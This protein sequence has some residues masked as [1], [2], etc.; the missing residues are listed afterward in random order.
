MSKLRMNVK[1]LAA[2]ALGIAA[3][4]TASAA[5]GLAFDVAKAEAYTTYRSI[6]TYEKT[7]GAE[8]GGPGAGGEYRVQ[9]A[10][11]G[12]NVMLN[13][14]TEGSASLVVDGLNVSVSGANAIAFEYQNV[15]AGSTVALTVKVNGTEAAAPFTYW[16]EGYD[17]A[18]TKYTDAESLTIVSVSETAGFTGRIILPLASFGSVSSIRSLEFDNE[19]GNTVVKNNF[20]KATLVNVSEENVPTELGEVWV[21]AQNNY[22]VTGTAF[23]RLMKKGELY[24]YAG[25][26]AYN[27]LGY[28]VSFAETVPLAEVKGL[29]FFV[30][31]TNVSSSYMYF[32]FTFR[33]G[34]KSVSVTANSYSA[35]YM[36]IKENGIAGRTAVN[37][38]ADKNY[39]GYMYFDMSSLELGALEGGLTSITVNSPHKSLIN[40]SYYMSDFALVTQT[41]GQLFGI[42]TSAPEGGSVSADKFYVAYGDEVTFTIAADIP[43]GYEKTVKV[44]G[45]N[46]SAELKDGLLTVIATGDLETALSYTPIDYTISYYDENGG[47]LDAGENPVSYNIES[48]TITLVGGA[49]RDGFEFTGWYDAAEGGSLVT[50]IATGSTGDKKLYARY[51]E[52]KETDY[53][54]SYY[55]GD[56]KLAAGEN[57]LFYNA[58]SGEILL[59]DAP[60]KTGYVFAGWCDE[61]GNKAAGI[62]AGSE[63]N[64]IF[65]AKYLLLYTISYYDEDG[66]ALYAG[67][68]PDSYTVES[69]RITLKEAAAKEGKIF[70]GWYD[71]REGGNAVVE[72]E[73]GSTGNKVLYARYE[74]IVYVVTYYDEDSGEIGKDEYT[75]ESGTIKFVDAPVKEGKL[76][77]GWYDALEGGRLVA[78]IP[79]GSTGDVSVYARYAE[80]SSLDHTVSDGAMFFAYDSYNS[81]QSFNGSIFS[82]LDGVNIRS[83]GLS[84]NPAD[85]AGIRVDVATDITGQRLSFEYNQT[86]KGRDLG[87]KITLFAGDTAYT[88]C[89]GGMYEV[90]GVNYAA[91]ADGLVY[92]HTSDDGGFLGTITVNAA[93][94]NVS[95]RVTKIAVSS[96]VTTYLRHNY[97]RIYCGK[98]EN[99]VDIWTSADGYERYTSDGAAELVEYTLMKKGEMKIVEASKNATTTWNYEQFGYNLPEALIGADGF[100]DITGIK[101][102]AV[103]VKNLS[104]TYFSWQTGIIDAKY[105]SV[106]DRSNEIAVYRW[107]TQSS[108][109]ANYCYSGSKFVTG[110]A[111]TVPAGFEGVIYLPFNTGTFAKASAA[112]IPDDAFPT[113]ILP[114]IYGGIPCGDTSAVGAD[115]IIGKIEMIRDDSAYQGYAVQLF[116]AKHGTISSEFDYYVNNSSVTITIEPE[117]GYSLKSGVVYMGDEA[118]EIPVGAVSY[119]FILSDT[120]IVDIS[121]EATEYTIAYRNT[122]NASNENPEGYKVSDANIVLKEPKREGYVFKGWYRTEDFVGEAVSL[123]DT[124]ECADI[125]LYAKWEEAKK[126]CGSIVGMGLIP[127]TAL[128]SAA[129]FV[130]IFVKKRGNGGE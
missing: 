59:K 91:G 124:S 65:Y 48:E 106:G 2:F 66:T 126:G 57:P 45:E 54:I 11:D 94:F 114:Y 44:N 81:S 108:T 116:E 100:I 35:N 80:I 87:L 90:N 28:Y 38:G 46:K 8:I 23:T 36:N 88:L 53:T 30:D 13:S 109:L 26:S 70:L 56:V 86:V 34:E 77:V 60:A 121:F 119:T 33:N 47:I 122:E 73:A 63:G 120:A 130:C 95:G 31:T 115:I 18:L 32:A 111:M 129:G 5:A 14:A 83:K 127:V 128:L 17:G 75:I 16:L 101:G 103:Y 113:K 22:T 4:G 97:G 107:L 123:I 55:D 118:L 64:R 39:R 12:V 104:D 37:L 96:P 89:E 102:L 84:E 21:P 40:V 79:S 51:A 27:N 9:S 117:K 43:D 49:G 78:E 61:D 3:A 71:G 25:A 67:D 74:P 24:V 72:I 19:V 58:S 15:E 112:T 98:G 93:D 82:E 110:G 125:V 99:A 20:G 7:G 42:K 41:P 85:Y 69:E 92:A 29:M 105:A 10:I 62:P 6:G 1:A 68:N 52:V 50:E 76:F